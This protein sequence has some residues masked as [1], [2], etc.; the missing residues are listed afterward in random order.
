[1]VLWYYAC[2]V[3]I[4]TLS[5]PRLSRAW[6]FSAAQTSGLSSSICGKLFFFFRGKTIFL[7]PLKALYHFPTVSGHLVKLSPIL[8]A[9]TAADLQHSIQVHLFIFSRASCRERLIMHIFGG[10]HTYQIH[11]MSHHLLLLNILCLNCLHYATS[12][13]ASRLIAVLFLH[14]AFQID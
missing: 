11:S 9:T 5:I 14:I 10:S 7:F 3:I 1:V 12:Q 13:F 2:T 8:S 6:V 4:S